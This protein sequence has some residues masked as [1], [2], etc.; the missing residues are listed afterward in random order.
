MGRCDDQSRS[1]RVT[2]D[3]SL[4]RQPRSVAIG[5]HPPSDTRYPT[6]SVDMDRDKYRDKYDARHHRPGEIPY[7]PTDMKSDVDK[8]ETLGSGREDSFRSET[9]PAL[10]DHNQPEDLKRSFNRRGEI[11]PRRHGFHPVETALPRSGG[12][13]TYDND[14]GSRI[15]DRHPDQRTEDRNNETDRVVQPQPERNNVRMLFICLNPLTLLA[16]SSRG[17]AETLRIG[18]VHGLLAP[19]IYRLGSGM[20]TRRLQPMT[21]PPSLPT[22]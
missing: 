10:E 3:S 9:N 14:K 19:T 5:S 15:S 7:V 12:V 18:Q 1:G 2:P 6:S 22:L 20:V 11:P 16:L 13:S 8:C 21:S 4:P 17:V